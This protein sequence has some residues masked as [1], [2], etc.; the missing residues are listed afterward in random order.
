M[1]P[2]LFQIGSADQ[3]W[4]GKPQTYKLT[5]CRISVIQVIL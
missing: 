2:Y 3:A 4:L 1:F 5:N